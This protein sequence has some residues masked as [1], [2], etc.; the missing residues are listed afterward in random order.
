MS[1]LFQSVLED[2]AEVT[3]FAP[4]LTPEYESALRGLCNYLE[5]EPLRSRPD[6]IRR[7]L[8][9][10]NRKFRLNNERVARVYAEAARQ[11]TTFNYH[12]KEAIQEAFDLVDESSF[13]LVL[14]EKHL[15]GQL[16]D[17][18]V[19]LFD[20]ISRADSVAAFRRE[21]EHP[22]KLRIE[23][24]DRPI[25]REILLSALSAFSFSLADEEILHRY[26]DDDYCAESY[27]DSF[28][29]QL[30]ASHPELYNR[31]R[32]LDIVRIDED[33]A[34]T[35]SDYQSL[36]SSLFRMIAG[37]YAELNNH[38]HLAILI[39]P[40]RING[41]FVSW[42]LAEDAKLFSE[43]HDNV[44]LR[45]AYFRHGKIAEETMAYIP[46]VSPEEAQF[47]LANEG[48]AYRDCFVF[49]ASADAL[50]N[51]ECLLLLFQKNR[52][53]ETPIP[54]PACR[55]HDVQ[56]NSYPTLGVRS[57][58]CN[59]VLCPDRSK[60]NRGKR[61]SFKALLMQEAITRAENLIPER[62]VRGWARDVQG[63]RSE[64]EILEMLCRFYSLNSDCVHL[65]GFRDLNA[66][67]TFGRKLISHESIAT[68]GGTNDF[69]NSAWFKRYVAEKPRAGDFSP[70]RGSARIE[71]FR[72]IHGDV[73]DALCAI[74]D[75]S[76]D[77]AV[78]SPPY[79][80]ARDYAQ[81]PNIYCYLY[82]MH[83]V[84]Q[85]CFRVLRPGSIFLFN[86]FDCFDN[87]RSLVFSAMGDKRLVL[88]SLIVDLF[89][90][91]GFVL[92][93]NIT[94]DKGEIEGKR[95]FNGGN[96]SPY[97]QSPFNCWEHLVVFEKPTHE[98]L[99]LHR[100]SAS[101]PSVLRAQPVIKMVRGENQHGHTAPFP[102]EVPGLLRTLLKP[103]AEVLDPF[104]G[105]ATTARALC[106][107]GIGVVCIE[108]DEDYCR[109]A[110]RMFNASAAS[111]YQLDL[112][113]KGK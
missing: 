83:N 55:S 87:E 89:R 75:E 22:S 91:A 21:V 111:G 60:Y 100:L 107:H 10:I 9:Q 59:N 88:S 41:A 109:L 56:G 68:G 40:I 108:R 78:T 23:K 53:D 71:N 76:F 25:D 12:E 6:R 24:A 64:A 95:A 31:D 67:E 77:G 82:D 80:N 47:Q 96:F 16:V 54:C 69:F 70:G 27:E 33:F 19:G 48:F 20:P 61:Y 65:F 13:A 97:Y 50:I 105:S 46:G 42:Q 43:K 102:E 72:L 2:F 4:Q 5:G 81:W 45:S 14:R 98:I 79:Y 37:S 84:I 52:R 29:L 92:L 39:S 94:W 103:G 101:L 11:R 86:I 15:N 90:R 85:Q 44:P 51:S 62:L 30:R 3:G 26:F 74:E 93:G 112:L 7:L 17:Q 28:W 73:F 18:L 49:A 34:S 57:W 35:F 106:K 8:A 58:E 32:A 38:G 1:S 66:Q 99:D 104:G 110:K 113:S 36:R 63:N